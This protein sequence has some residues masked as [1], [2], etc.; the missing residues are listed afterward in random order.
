V[1]ASWTLLNDGTKYN[2][3]LI[4]NEGLQEWFGYSVTNSSSIVSYDS[5]LNLTIP[6]SLT[7][8]NGVDFYYM[9][10]ACPK[11][12]TIN[13]L[14]LCCNLINSEYSIPSDVFFTIPLNANFGNLIC[15]NPFDPSMCNV[16]GGKEKNIE[17]SFYDTNF[18][19]VVIRDTDITITLVINK[20]DIY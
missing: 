10:N 20:S 3:Q 15:V 11:L 16:R 1:G 13:S 6:R 9:S 18:N 17:I 7:V 19:P 12:N 2:P 5:N 14:V 4:L 8:L